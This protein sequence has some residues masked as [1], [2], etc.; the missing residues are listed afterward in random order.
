MNKR[1][2]I[3]K[4]KDEHSSLNFKKIT[5]HQ[6]DGKMYATDVRVAFNDYLDS[7][8]RYGL[9]TEKQVNNITL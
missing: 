1:E 7:L 5:D 8:Y 9:I 4:F 2:I 6:G 3:R